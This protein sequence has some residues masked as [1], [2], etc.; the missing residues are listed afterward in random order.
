MAAGICVSAFLSR[1]HQHNLSLRRISRRTAR[2]FCERF[3]GRSWIACRVRTGSQGIN[4]D[5]RC[6]TAAGLAFGGA[7]SLGPVLDLSA[8]RGQPISASRRSAGAAELMNAE[9]NYM[10]TRLVNNSAE[11]LYGN[12]WFVALAKEREWRPA[13]STCGRLPT[14][15]PADEDAH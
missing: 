9:L 15:R 3:P 5:S 6:F 1:A 2:R 8:H 4:A 11:I 10:M 13:R 7:R 12:S 14:G